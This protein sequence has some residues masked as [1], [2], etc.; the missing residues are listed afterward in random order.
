LILVISWLA[1]EED[2]PVINLTKP[3]LITK[4]SD[5]TLISNLIKSRIRLA[6]DNYYL[7]ENIMEMLNKNDGAG[8]IVNH[9]KINLF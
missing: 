8:V 4:N 7:D 6:C 9:T 3:I 5:P 1:Y 2:S